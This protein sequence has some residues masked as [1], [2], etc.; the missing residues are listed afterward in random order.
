MKFEYNIKELST[1]KSFK[2]DYLNTHLICDVSKIVLEYCYIYK[3][4]DWIDINKLNWDKLSSNKTPLN[5]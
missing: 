3:L 2:M 4:L 1:I 5:Y